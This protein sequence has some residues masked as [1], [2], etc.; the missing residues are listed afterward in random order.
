MAHGRGTSPVLQKSF[1]FAWHAGVVLP[2][3][4]PIAECTLCV[5]ITDTTHAKE[6]TNAIVATDSTHPATTIQSSEQGE[7]QC[8][9]RITLPIERC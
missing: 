1:I 8:M 9:V 3:V 6:V 4:S 5:A 7:V 2:A